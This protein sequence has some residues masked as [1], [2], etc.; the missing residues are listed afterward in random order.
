[1]FMG[2]RLREQR[3][4]RGF[5]QQELGDVIGVSRSAIQKQESGK[6]K[7]IDTLSLEL[8]SHKLNC[9]PAYLM[10][11]TDDPAPL[12]QKKSVTQTDD[13]LSANKKNLL[14][15]VALM[16]DDDVDA[17]TV[18]VEQVIRRHRE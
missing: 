1:M 11:W 4:L 14:D 9:S 2:E 10:G 7:T 18:I 12:P 8:L 6:S 15:Q 16:S 13:G 17:L 5:S 3:I